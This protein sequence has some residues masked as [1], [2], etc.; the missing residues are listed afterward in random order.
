MK[1]MK[2]IT[3]NKENKKIVRE[4]KEMNLKNRENYVKNNL[5]S[6]KMKFGQRKNQFSQ[7]KLSQKHQ[8]NH[9]KFLII[10]VWQKGGNIR[11]LG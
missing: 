2:S 11:S 7:K 10:V 5:K 9:L 3:R 1:M 8:N 6:D 4:C